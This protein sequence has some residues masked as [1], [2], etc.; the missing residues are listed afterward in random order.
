MKKLLPVLL[1]S[2]F[3]IFTAFRPWENPSRLLALKWQ[4]D[5]EAFKPSAQ[6]LIKEN[7]Q[8]ANLSEAQMKQVVE[9]ATQMLKGTTL[10]FKSDGTYEMFT[11]KEGTVT[12]TW[13]LS[14]ASKELTRQSHKNAAE[15]KPPRK[16]K[17]LE[18]TDERLHLLSD[19]PQLPEQIFTPAVEQT[20]K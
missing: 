4:F 18:L 15:N 14:P 6:Q 8:T 13:S 7:P 20:L 11:K 10:T 2:L 3:A 5:T 16:F 9:Q 17:V 1:M 19:T 12:G